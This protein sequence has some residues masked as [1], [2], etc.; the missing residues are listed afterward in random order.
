MSKCPNARSR[1]VRKGP[2]SSMLLLLMR[3]LNVASLRLEYW[4]SVGIR[5]GGCQVLC[6]LEEMPT[7][8]RWQSKYRI[9]PLIGPKV[10]DP[11]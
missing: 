7:T 6:L 2:A 8:L 1:E 5:S 4:D 3:A 11:R 9:P 10:G